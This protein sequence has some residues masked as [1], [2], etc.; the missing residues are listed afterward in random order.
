MLPEMGTLEYNADVYQQMCGGK[1]P[2]QHPV[3]LIWRFDFPNLYHGLE[4]LM[5]ALQ[6][7]LILE[8]RPAETHMAFI[9]GHRPHHYAA[10]WETSFAESKALMDEARKSRTLCLR[11]AVLPSAS[12]TGSLWP[13]SFSINNPC[14]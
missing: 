3:M 4:G 8:L 12:R 5:G 2:F 11:K 7:A 6:S 10:L 9:D 1:T 13:S 14:R